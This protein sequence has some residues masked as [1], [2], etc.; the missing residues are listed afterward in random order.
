MSAIWWQRDLKRGV[1]TWPKNKTSVPRR[2]IL[3]RQKVELLAEYKKGREINKC[4]VQVPSRERP[5]P[6]AQLSQRLDWLDEKGL[7]L[8]LEHWTPHDLRRT[9]RTNLGRLGC[10]EAVGVAAIGHTKK[11]VVS[12]Y[13][14]HTHK[15]EV[16]VWLQKW[17][18]KLD[19]IL[20]DE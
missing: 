14:L 6:Q 17:R 20:R 1:F 2:I 16:G 4:P 8:D 13:D 19:W 12:I 5:L 11:G 15:P 9:C 18:D 3:P 10:P 7:L